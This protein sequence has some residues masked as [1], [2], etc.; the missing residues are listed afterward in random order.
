MRKFYKLTYNFFILLK[1]LCPIISFCYTFLWVI[2]FLKAPFYNTLAIPFEPFAQ[3]VN[4]IHPIN[5]NYEGELINMSYIVCSG[6]FIIFHYIFDFFALRIVDLYNLEEDR[7]ERKRNRE[8][9][10]ININLQKELNKEIKKH[11]NFTLLFNLTLKSGYNLAKDRSNEFNF[12]KKEF[13]THII[14][15][16]NLK[17]NESKCI[18]TDKLFISCENFDSFDNFMTDFI[19]DVRA[20]NKTAE[21]KDIEVEFSISLDAIKSSKNMFNTIELLEKI[22]SFNYKNKVVATS[23]FKLRYEQ[24]KEP[25]YKIVPLGI[26]RFFKDVDDYIDFDLY[27]LKSKN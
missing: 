7:L 24:I 5:I 15:N 22:D 9:R 23:A 1:V 17:Y 3:F 14:K 26:S 8:V 20:F 13:Y 2:S 10:K 19:N 21:Q 18:I 25:K 12:L 27:N 11:T 16:V 4:I 6:L